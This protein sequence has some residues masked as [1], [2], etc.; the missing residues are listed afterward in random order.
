[1]IGLRIIPSL[2][3]P[4]IQQELLSRLLH[5][6]LSNEKHQTNTHLHYNVSYPV[7]E[8]DVD[9][10]TTR[11]S[12][13]DSS[14]KMHSF[15]NDDPRRIFA[16][17]APDVHKPISVQRFLNR[18]LRWMT[19]GGQYNWTDKNYPLE[20]PPPFPKDIATLLRQIFPETDAQA[21]IV[22]FYSAGDTLSVHRDVSEECDTG[23]ISI[24]FGCDGLFMIG[25]DDSSS[26]EVIRLRSGDAVYMT[27][28]SRFAWHGVPKIISATCPS[29]LKDWPASAAAGVDE[30][31]HWKGWMAGK[32]INLNVRQMKHK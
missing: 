11:M 26:S 25:H 20:A 31:T 14:A 5:R 23:L 1:M 27:G 4:T 16:P 13:A 22:N 21:A 8:G 17:K 29:W 2:I 3:P 10:G 28:R 19:L 18:K 9:E 32:R 7:H 15:F 24:S 6:D 12:S 30:I